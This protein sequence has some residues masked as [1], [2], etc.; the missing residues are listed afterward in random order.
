MD[1][2]D[3]IDRSKQSWFQTALQVAAMEKAKT[4]TTGSNLLTAPAAIKRGYTKWPAGMSVAAVA[5]CTGCYC[6]GRTSDCLNLW[7]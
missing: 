2:W 1:I 4:A 7:R 6:Q 3:I 5:D